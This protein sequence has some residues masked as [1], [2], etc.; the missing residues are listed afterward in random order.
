MRRADAGESVQHAMRLI[1]RLQ[2]IRVGLH[3][4]HLLVVV[5][6]IAW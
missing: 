3:G 4:M 5:L 1:E 2:L 6:L